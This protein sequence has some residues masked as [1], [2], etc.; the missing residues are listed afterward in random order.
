MADTLKTYREKRDFKVTSEPAEGG[1]AN[2]DALAFVVQKHWASRLHYDFRLELDGAM[3]SW[4]VPKGPTYDPTVKRMAV[5]VEDHPIAYNQ[6]EGEIPKGQYGAGKVIIWDE[7]IWQPLSDPRKGYRD[8]HLKFELHGSKLHGRWALVRMK[9]KGEKQVP[10]LLI[11]EKDALAK[12]E[13]EFSLVD[14]YPDSV[15]PLRGEPRKAPAADAAAADAAAADAAAADAASSSAAGDADLPG[16]AAPL[17][18]TLR[19]Q[20]ATL[21]ERPPHAPGEWIHELKFDGY[22]VMARLDRGEARLYTRNGHDW[23]AR[24]PQLARAI[25]ALPVENAWIDG[26]IVVMADDGNPSFQALQ[27]AFDE[28]RAERILYYAFDLPY[29]TGRDLREEPLW[30]RR[31]ILEQVIARGE[32]PLRFS[33]AFDKP[34]SDLVASACKLGLE[35][36][37]AKR[38]DAPYVTRR[39]DTWI[40]LKCARRQEFVIAGYT[41]PQGTR[42]GL[43]ALV[44]AVHDQEGTLR[45]A[46]NVG[47]GFDDRMLAD[48]VARLSKIERADSPLAPGAK[49]GR[50]VHWVEPRLVAEVS[51]GEWTGAGHVRHAVFRGLREDK[52]A[53]AIVRETPERGA[54]AADTQAEDGGK[55]DRRTQA[56][57][58]A[59]SSKAAGSTTK[60]DA[61]DNAAAGESGKK[62]KAS[63]ADGAARAGQ[64]DIGARAKPGRLTS[65]DRVI[66]EQSG[67]TKLDLARYYALVA[68][69][70]LPHLAGRPTSFLR[71]P[72]GIGAAMFFQKHL[73]HAMPGVLTLPQELDPDHPPLLEVPS[74]TALMSAVQMNVVEFH[75][76]NAHKDAID[77][78]DRM[79]FD[80]D[81]GEGVQWT[82]VVEG[83]Q[84][85]R[86]L[87][88]ELGLTAWLKTSGGKGL[89]VVVPLRRQHDWDTVKGCAQAIVRHL[90]QTVPQRFVAKSG[91]RNRVGK[92]FVDYLRN[93]FGA[94]TVAA[95]SARA[96]PGLGVS[97]PL[98]WDELKSLKRG[99]QWTV[100]NI[101]D[102]L[103][104]GDTPWD[105]YRPQ[106]L[107]AA[108]DAFK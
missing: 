94:T 64:D 16:R 80:L 24:M 75:T 43:G 104:V 34:V 9:G 37:I 105:D 107:A 67:A 58:T 1:D 54:G 84:L 76:W 106:S 69:Q 100:R 103:D 87:L 78:P 11:K 50:K 91:P 41:E 77:K 49:P 98:A 70:I 32:E 33:A 55:A 27:N 61:A 86:T 30:R 62:T 73:E 19:P 102:R 25:A 93:G 74:D 7:G 85:V 57:R 48:L 5:Q 45:H 51:F 79:V 52:P 108:L 21:V 3:K 97:V 2:P 28:E 4:A 46:G 101:H 44:L 35:G 31:E 56:A 12:P 42:V 8:G 23:T 17:P 36:I 14:E 38:R 13:S 90:A 63:K 40:K 60:A 81:P 68:P 99:D 20:L 15:V 89:H 26:E 92:I 96:R 53:S 72:A 39:S 10:W 47:T 29:V 59:K 66:D 22:R 71:A 65:P 88:Q 95:W 82:A 83:A 6:F 18:D